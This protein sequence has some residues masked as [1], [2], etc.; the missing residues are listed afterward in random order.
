MRI[1]Y[2]YTSK[3]SFSSC[4]LYRWRL[5]REFN[6]KKKL[7]I[8]IGLNPSRASSSLDDQTIKRLLCFSNLWGYGSLIVVNLFARVSASPS[9]LRKCSD[10]NFKDNQLHHRD[11]ISIDV[12]SVRKGEGHPLLSVH[13]A[14][15]DQAMKHADQAEGITRSLLHMGARIGDLMEVTEKAIDPNSPGGSSI[16][17]QEK[18]KIYKAIKEVEDKI[19]TLKLSIK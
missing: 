12:A 7:M 16:S 19:A 14:L 8:F 9:I 10:P 3:A 15:V 18:D 11:A 5:E 13:Q 4:G 2:A 17:K 6:N 1:P